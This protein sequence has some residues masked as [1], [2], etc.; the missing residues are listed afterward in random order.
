[1]LLAVYSA[2]PFLFPTRHDFVYVSF[3]LLCTNMCSNPL[4]LD[5]SFDP[6]NA[7]LSFSALIQPGCLVP[8]LYVICGSLAL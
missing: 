6:P 8:G 7:L 4:V 1:M 5:I 3:P 2:F